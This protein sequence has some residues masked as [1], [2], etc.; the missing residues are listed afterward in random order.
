MDLDHQEF[1]KYIKEANEKA[2]IIRNKKMLT[3]NGS[4]VSYMDYI[5]LKNFYIYQIW[6][7]ILRI[8]SLI[9]GSKNNY[10]SI[11]DSLIDLINYSKLAYAEQKI[12]KKNENNKK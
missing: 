4:N 1:I 8:K 10:E 5:C 3:Y 11:E 6:N 2:E 9:N 12:N 7:K